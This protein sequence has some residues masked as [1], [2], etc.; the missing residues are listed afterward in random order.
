MQIFCG[1]L[2]VESEAFSF[3][4]KEKLCVNFAYLVSRA[5][6]G[7]EEENFLLIPLFGGGEKERARETAI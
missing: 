1:A 3:Y 4:S 2:W 5:M 7:M 6:L